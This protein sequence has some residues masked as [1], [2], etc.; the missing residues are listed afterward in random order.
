MNRGQVDL[1]TLS[2]RA[3]GRWSAIGYSVKSGAVELVMP[4]NGIEVKALGASLLVPG[5]SDHI[6]S[7]VRS[8]I[9]RGLTP[10]GGG[11]RHRSIGS[12]ASGV[13][14][15]YFPGEKLPH[16]RCPPGSRRG[17][18]WTDAMG[19][20]CELGGSRAALSRIGERI[21]RT[22]RGEKPRGDLPSV[23]QRLDVRRVET[24]AKL[25]YEHPLNTL[26]AKKAA[27]RQKK[28]A[29]DLK[30]TQAKLEK[31]SKK[32]RKSEG[33][34]T[35]VTEKTPKKPEVPKVVKPK[36]PRKKR[37]LVSLAAELDF[38]HP[39]NKLKPKKKRE[40]KKVR[41]WLGEKKKLTADA[42]EAKRLQRRKARYD[43]AVEK[44][45][46][47]Y[48]SVDAI[49]K[50]ELDK[51]KKI[52]EPDAKL[53]KGKRTTLQDVAS[54][55][56]YDHPANAL[57]PEKSPAA[58]AIDAVVDGAA[59]P[60]TPKVVD[61]PEVMPKPASDKPEVVKPVKAAKLGGKQFGLTY[62]NE[63]NVNNKALAFALDEGHATYVVKL[64]NGKFRIV[65]DARWL[66]LEESGIKTEFVSA[67]LP[68][69]T[70]HNA[71]DLTDSPDEII[72]DV[73]NAI[74]ANKVLDKAQIKELDVPK[75]DSALVLSKTGV[76]LPPDLNIDM[77]TDGADQDFIDAFAKQRQEINDFWI[78][79]LGTWETGNNFY[80]ATVR[81]DSHIAKREAAG[82]SQKELAILRTERKNFLAVFMPD[83][84]GEVDPYARF[85][86]LQPKRRLAIV[87]EA[88]LGD[89]VVTPKAAKKKVKVPDEKTPDLP[90]FGEDVV[91]GDV[92][93]LNPPDM[94]SPLAYASAYD[95]RV[96]FHIENEYEIDK[97]AA[98]MEQKKPLDISAI[99]DYSYV[100]IDDDVLWGD[101]NDTNIKIAD[102]AS[103]MF[104]S[105]TTGDTFEQNKK[106]LIEL[107]ARKVMLNKWNNNAQIAIEEH[108]LNIPLDDQMAPIVEKTPISVGEAN[109]AHM[110][111]V[112]LILEL[113]EDIQSDA[114]DELKA[115]V[116]IMEQNGYGLVLQIDYL[117]QV[118]KDGQQSLKD[119]NDTIE[120]H[121]NDGNDLPESQKQFMALQ[122]AHAFAK[123]EEATKL[124]M[125]IQEEIDN[126]TGDNP[127]TPDTAPD[128]ATP[129]TAPDPD[130]LNALKVLFNDPEVQ[131]SF[132]FQQLLENENAK[133]HGNTLAALTARYKKYGEL[134]DDVILPLINSE[135]FKNATKQQQMSQLES[136]TNTPSGFAAAKMIARSIV[137]GQYGSPEWLG[138]LEQAYKESTDMPTSAAALT[139]LEKRI[140][141]L[142]AEHIALK[143]RMGQEKDP[144]VRAAI[145]HRLAN[146]NAELLTHYKR[147]TNYYISTNN[148]ESPKFQEFIAEQE[149]LVD[150]LPPNV[151]GML[152][153][154]NPVAATNLVAT[155]FSPAKPAKGMNPISPDFN[156]GLVGSIVGKDGKAI[157]VSRPIGHKGIYTQAQANEHLDLTGALSDIPDA[158]LRDAMR[159]NLGGRFQKFEIKEGYNLTEGFLDTQTGNTY[160]VKSAHR[161]NQEYVQEIAGGRY[162]QMLGIP[163]VGF[164]IAG[165]V[166]IL[167]DKDGNMSPQ[168]P[169]LIEMAGNLFGQ[170]TVKNVT[171]PVDPASLAR[172]VVMDRTLN[173]YDRTHNN[174]IAVQMADGSVHYQ[175]IDLGNAF[176]DFKGGDEET[177]GFLE[178]TKTD[179]I[180]PSKIAKAELTTPERRLAYAVAMIDTVYRYQQGDYK[181]AFTEI[182]DRQ[183]LNDEARAKLMQ[184]AEFLEK[185]KTS[186]DWDAMTRAALSDLGMSQGEIDGA[187]G[188][189]SDSLS[190][191]NI[192]NTS[193]NL[194]SVAKSVDEMPKFNMGARVLYDGDSIEQFHLSINNGEFALP[195]ADG[196]VGD[197]APGTQFTLK[198]HGS[199]GKS[200]SMPAKD[201]W[202]PSPGITMG[203]ASPEGGYDFDVT[204]GETPPSVTGIKTFTKVMP[205][206]TVIMVTKQTSANSGKTSSWHNNV[207]I[208][209]P[210]TAADAVTSSS[211]KDAM[212]AVG[213]TSHAPP[214][215]A[216]LETFASFKLASLV[217]GPNAI[218]TKSP[219]ELREMLKEK[220][221]SMDDVTVTVDSLGAPHIRFT[222]E[223][224]ARNIETI[225]LG[226]ITHK[227]EKQW[228][229]D[230]N[231]TN[232]VNII[233]S[234]SLMSITDRYNHGIHAQ[235][236]STPADIVNGVADYVFL[237]RQMQNN[238]EG[239]G[240]LDDLEYPDELR[241]YF[242]PELLASST[243]WYQA[244][245]DTYGDLTKR[246]PNITAEGPDYYGNMM[247]WSDGSE[248]M[249][250]ERLPFSL[251]LIGVDPAQRQA[252]INQLK[253]SG[254][255]EIGGIPIEDII[256]PTGDLQST[257]KRTAQI[258]DQ[259]ASIWANK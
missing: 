232:I 104:Q 237:S 213:V 78:K 75:G 57:K 27:K 70:K 178:K 38:E 124:K 136:A 187:Y 252:I 180:T 220:G 195:D 112:F 130:G 99:P 94:S 158:Y 159:A 81:I 107:T 40:G 233:R 148:F 256:V 73:K 249:L 207:R 211:L 28:I 60:K 151:R 6:G 114:A 90:A 194:Q 173:Y 83:E 41:T 140:K 113:E 259:I 7:P 29:E 15:F 51:A 218:G 18:K 168:A 250:R 135:S 257:K 166:E 134:F 247:P 101:L 219:D 189:H 241:V 23:S 231:I 69:G 143:L 161:N 198:L 169:I 214:T 127:P 45:T 174:F 106:K 163:A 24:A 89:L 122:H 120:K 110:A 254:M 212:E 30:K 224:T 35:V 171:G 53:P 193:S 93:G 200:R 8:G 64:D 67:F 47:K 142:K 91:P 85:N 86:Y 246:G 132:N 36:K 126:I 39:A 71:I 210:G 234:G 177:A 245:F 66:S 59:K 2:G 205:D 58:V 201:G 209:I 217:L 145:S 32:V 203:V 97:L 115:Y 98:D 22:A 100:E 152:D 190:T 77:L 225:G 131:A 44:L 156:S 185:R 216:D 20:D 149:M 3:L 226:F 253:E 157:A 196:V 129:D 248:V 138:K 251:A 63:K 139:K 56:D 206:G 9:S 243:D 146:T 37:S 153:N 133:M 184:H 191:L 25:D 11:S 109:A 239:V 181:A 228:D 202:V 160:V 105:E 62:T 42:I 76:F 14:E 204:K 154:A 4:D 92:P 242:P 123:A 72:A 54:Q 197:L 17:G 238:E 215:P 87:E 240:T 65:D 74:E 223:A 230:K 111:R 186:L 46:E 26:E 227:I 179:N 155:K 162:Q 141:E 52:L 137:V 222:E 48:G 80:D 221:F 183:G 19:S 21:G 258:K 167:E 117:D 121:A 128:P 10:G 119:L 108:N 16:F 125:S 103:Q 165:P 34:R 236:Q 255:T 188:I 12:A 43:K 95:F 199:A 182:A 33:K 31:D 150:S 118:I 116:A 88:G 102:L 170:A 176:Y 172:M 49:P 244:Q 13:V 50:S 55:L 96:G 164:R 147:A 61:K 175:P 192:G 208:I 144:I 229:A 68:D 79:E 235:G 84:N 1:S 82:A 5:D